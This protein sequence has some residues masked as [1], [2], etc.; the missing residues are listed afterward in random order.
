MSLAA[1]RRCMCAHVLAQTVA[2]HE[3]L[4][5]DAALERPFAAVR[6]HVP[7]QVVRLG[8]GLHAN[9]ALMGLLIGVR[10]FVATQIVSL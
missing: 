5:T 8:E 1:S 3:R 9:V 4:L 7:T 10:L 6:L 2:E